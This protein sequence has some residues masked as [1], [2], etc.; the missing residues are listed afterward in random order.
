MADT[1]TFQPDSPDAEV[2]RLEPAP[3]MRLE[4]TIMDVRFTKPHNY[5]VVL[6]LDEG[7]KGN[8][9]ANLRTEVC[10]DITDHPRFSTE[11]S[12]I[13]MDVVDD[14]VSKDANLKGGGF[15]VSKEGGGGVAL[16][17]NVVIPLRPHM[18]NLS[19]GKAVSVEE[20]FMSEGENGQPVQV[21]TLKVDILLTDP[22]REQSPAQQQ[23]QHQSRPGGREPELKVRATV[24]PSAQTP[25]TLQPPQMRLQV[26]QQPEQPAQSHQPRQMPA[27]TPVAVAAPAPTP[28]PAVDGSPFRVVTMVVR[29]AINL[30]PALDAAT[31]QP[32]SPTPFVAIKSARDAAARRPA[33]SSTTA[34]R[35]SRHPIWNQTLVAEVLQEDLDRGD[36]AIIVTIINHDTKRRIAQVAIPAHKLVPSEQYNLDIQLFRPQGSSS[37][38]PSAPANSRLYLSATLHDSTMGE[39]TLLLANPHLT[40]LEVLV[41]GFALGRPL[42]YG[43]DETVGVVRLV[44]D[45]AA[46]VERVT[47]L[48]HALARSQPLESAGI[49]AYPLEQYQRAEDDRT[50]AH[51]LSSR[52]LELSLPMPS[53]AQLTAAVGPGDTPAWNQTLYFTYPTAELYAEGAALLVEVFQRG[54]HSSENGRRQLGRRSG[55][56]EQLSA[57]GLRRFCRAVSGSK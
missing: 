25:A 26:Q 19:A 31:G 57:D 13:T 21:G 33:R 4:V 51:T 43:A 40:R 28:P 44:P 53:A 22:T 56:E 23:Q 9:Q 5:F 49:I 30:P 46:Y 3:S 36:G 52:G 29:H 34:V 47:E 18:A 16:E 42:P 17:G 2:S 8:Q 15:R 24:L 1:A 54:L 12:K 55:A 37:A 45:A 10:A 32:V 35:N 11:S 6:T 27:R 7:L 41:K 14:F 50:Q 38:N 39:K 20:A 48:Q